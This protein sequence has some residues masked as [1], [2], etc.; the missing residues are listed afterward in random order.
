ML[1]AKDK[2]GDKVNPWKGGSA[3][4]PF[5]G[6]NVIAA[7]GDINVHHWRHD[8]ATN[9]DPWGEPET[10]WHRQWKAKFP[11]NWREFI[12]TRNDE[13]HIADLKTQSGLVVEFQNSSISNT[14]IQIR[15]AFYGTMIWVINAD[16]FKDNFEIRSLVRSK[17]RENELKHNT[18][19]SYNSGDEDDLLEYD[20]EIDKLEHEVGVVNHSL[21][22]VER[23]IREYEVYSSNID[24]AVKELFKSEYLYNVLRDFKSGYI[25]DIKKTKTEILKTQE[26]IKSIEEK[27][28][29]IEAL[30]RFK[31]SGYEEYRVVDFS[32]VSSENF[33][34]C[35][36]VRTESIATIF[37]E[38]IE[39]NSESN[40][41]WY[42]GKSN[43]Y[44]LIVDPT[45]KLNSLQYQIEEANQSNRRLERQKDEKLLN[46][47]EELKKWLKEQSNNET[48]KISQYQN[49][50]QELRCEI[51]QCHKDKERRRLEILKENEELEQELESEKT[52][53]E[54][55]IKRTYKGKYSYYW[56]HRRK[57]WDYA[58]APLFLDFG[59]HIFE[60]LTDSQLRK[61]DTQDFIAKIHKGDIG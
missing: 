10:E 12:I 37:P 24:I 22:N 60:V 15:E 34:K 23:K 46:L 48:E 27:L 4:C 33:N 61:M 49:K 2:Y 13:K 5:C 25:S 43:T 9:C 54:I 40:F 44:T 56:K 29:Q 50:I 55:R 53:E 39:L 52:K 16:K 51:E 26:E 59:S 42:A 17:L 30:T 11:E 1:A 7:C 21:E 31:S 28:H 35:K 41:R 32:M 18:Y 3:F 19:Y 6:G 57:S 58:S 38:I 47:K 20:R 36:V 8:A 45:E 14:T